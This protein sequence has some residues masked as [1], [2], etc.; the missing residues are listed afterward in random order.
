MEFSKLEL[1]ASLAGFF[2]AYWVTTAVYSVTFHKLAKFP[3]P[4][5]AAVSY[6]PEFYYDAILGGQY[7]KK[8]VQMHETY[9]PL[10]R[11]NPGELHLNDPHFYEKVYAG[12][13]QKTERDKY[14]FV[15]AGT[16]VALNSTIDHDLHYRRRG[17]ISFLFSNKAITTI[18]PSIQMKVD[19]LVSLLKDAHHNGDKIV[20]I[21]L[22][23]ALTTDV[24]TQFAYGK[25]FGELEKPGFPCPI[26][27]DV[28][29][30]LQSMPYR[31]FLPL[32]TD[33]FQLLPNAA[34]RRLTPAV[35]SFL[36]LRDYLN[37]RAIAALNNKDSERKPGRPTTL[38]DALTDDAKIPKHE[39]TVQRV[40]EESELVLLAGVDTTARTLTTIVAIMVKYPAI[41][42][43]LRHEMTTA[44][45]KFGEKPTWKQLETLPY[46]TA[47]ISEALRWHNFMTGR[48]PRVPVEPL[49]YKDYVIPGGTPIGAMPWLLN[50]HPD[51]FPEPDA[52]RPER[53]LEAAARGERLDK[54]LVTFTKGTRMCLGIN[55]AYAELYLVT[56]ALVLNFGFELV[57]GTGLE[58]VI[59][60]R[61]YALA[62][63]KKYGFGV[64]FVVKE[65]LRE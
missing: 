61:D 3:G 29:T 22:F 64:D 27:R 60:Y 57:N 15:R 32:L 37:T 63:N 30:L 39:Q 58:D 54:Y 6:V 53:W 50:R 41:V 13:A 49:P 21:Q 31:M 35:A 33:A 34:L 7:F 62:F 24:I 5:W 2:V 23:G 9:G 11:I 55:L 43:K 20:A 44:V 19:R 25:S 28:N 56:A 47:F 48:M 59:P 4:W 12:A 40:R 17:Y 38:L 65:V 18:E 16:T 10:V 42:A 1:A 51:I 8:I 52:F 46:L 14:N 26:E 36:D 45:D